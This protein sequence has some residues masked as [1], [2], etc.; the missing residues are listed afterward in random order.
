MEL[1]E[2]RGYET[3]GGKNSVRFFF[4]SKNGTPRRSTR[5]VQEFTWQTVQTCTT[6]LRTLVMHTY[7]DVADASTENKQNVDR[8]SPRDVA[9]TGKH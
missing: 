8:Q 2:P 4:N 6:T 5:A 9:K 3:E 7:V 1:A